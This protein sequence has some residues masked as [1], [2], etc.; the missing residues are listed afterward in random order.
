MKSKLLFVLGIG[1]SEWKTV[2][3]QEVSEP[4][5]INASNTLLINASKQNDFTQVEK[6][7]QDPKVNIDHQDEQRLTALIWA[8]QENS[9][10]VV[11]YLLEAEADMDIQDEQ[12]RT[13]LMIASQNAHEE[14]V[15][16]LIDRGADTEL[17]NVQGNTALELAPKDSPIVTMF[18]RAKVND[19]DAASRENETDVTLIVVLGMVG[20]VVLVLGGV[21]VSQYR[22]LNQTQ[23]KKKRPPAELSTDV[24]MLGSDLDSY[25]TMAP[26]NSSTFSDASSRYSDHASYYQPSV[27]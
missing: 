1:G 3:S 24:P 21:Y 14:I 17:E 6:L 22:R 27:V 8:A 5:L 19:N 13:A 11:P 20:F 16:M 26:E 12:G 18:E 9:F 23:K 2:C 15:Q 4:L 7:L 10:F 25:A